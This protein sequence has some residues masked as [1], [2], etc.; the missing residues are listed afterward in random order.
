MVFFQFLLIDEPIDVSATWESC[1]A[2]L[3]R[4]Q[5]RRH[6]TSN[7]RQPARQL[8]F[9]SKPFRLRACD[10]CNSPTYILSCPQ[11]KSPAR[12]FGFFFSR[13]P[14]PPNIF[15]SA[16]SSSTIGPI[17]RNGDFHLQMVSF[18]RIPERSISRATWAVGAFCC[19]RASP[20]LCFG[21]QKALTRIRHHK[22]P[23]GA[24]PP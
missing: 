16:A 3:C 20:N 15:Q 10:L 12:P 7:S 21:G 23:A 24:T 2:Y 8:P 19:N 14:P 1:A 5:R 13:N 9:P 22:L 6:F 11:A 18:L 4:H 17:S